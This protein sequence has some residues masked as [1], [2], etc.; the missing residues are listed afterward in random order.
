[1][2]HDPHSQEKVDRTGV[3]QLDVVMDIDN[4]MQYPPEM[5]QEESTDRRPVDASLAS[6]ASQ[7]QRYLDCEGGSPSAL[8]KN[9][10]V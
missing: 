5:R 1:M 4:S 9:S 6:G 8:I 10:Y 3:E 7:Y 2:S